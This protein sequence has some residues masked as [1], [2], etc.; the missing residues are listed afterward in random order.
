MRES[1]S[2]RNGYTAIIVK[3]DKGK[4]FTAGSTFSLEIN[5]P[6]SNYFLG[7]KYWGVH[8][9]TTDLNRTLCNKTWRCLSDNRML[10]E[11]VCLRHKTIKKY[12]TATKANISRI[13][14]K[15]LC[16]SW[17]SYR[18]IIET[19][20][21][22]QK[23]DVLKINNIELNNNTFWFNLKKLVDNV[24]RVNSPAEAVVECDRTSNILKRIF[25]THTRPDEL[26]TRCEL[27]YLTCRNKQCHICAI[28]SSFFDD[29]VL[30]VIC[31]T[32][33]AKES[34]T[35]SNIQNQTFLTRTRRCKCALRG[36]RYKPNKVETRPIMLPFGAGFN[37]LKTK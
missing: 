4:L 1:N 30:R 18:F 16:K 31:T 21:H 34:D 9:N 19:V 26:S 5:N 15:F 24:T 23:P 20:Y 33:N 6:R 37:E 36:L 32:P 3:F 8:W 27:M 35:T 10:L 14:D 22:R 11:D 13:N 7:R 28:L 29:N 25:L 17:T 12:F 2:L